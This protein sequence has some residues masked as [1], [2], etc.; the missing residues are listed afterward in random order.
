MSFTGGKLKLKGHD[1]GVKKKKKKKQSGEGAE[2]A[3]V[4]VQL[5]D[6]EAAAV[7]GKVGREALR[8]AWTVPHRS[9]ACMKRMQWHTGDQG[10]L[11]AGAV[12]GGRRPAHGGGEAL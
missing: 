7:V 6:G 3:L 12:A 4:P 8:V 5:G 9:Q 10:R 2:T 1:G 11:C